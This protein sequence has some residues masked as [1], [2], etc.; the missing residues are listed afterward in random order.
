[1]N[2][3]QLSNQHPEDH[4]SEGNA[5][6]DSMFVPNELARA[7]IDQK[8]QD[9][10]YAT[11]VYGPDDGDARRRHQALGFGS[12]GSSIVGKLKQ[13]LYEPSDVYMVPASARTTNERLSHG[14]DAPQPRPM[15]LTGYTVALKSFGKQNIKTINQLV[16]V[17]STD[18]VAYSKG[19]QP[20]Y[21]TKWVNAIEMQTYEKH[22]AVEDMPVA[23]AEYELPGDTTVQRDLGHTALLLYD[24]QL[25]LV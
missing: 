20:V 6:I 12:R 24:R 19:G 25:Q 16:E 11:E 8:I 2:H 15:N 17:Q 21:A 18:P 23:A 4:K 5:G 22:E 10:S 13:G 14:L 9:I 1:M 7:M 3:N